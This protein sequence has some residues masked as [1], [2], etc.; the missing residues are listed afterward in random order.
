VNLL[1]GEGMSEKI[2]FELFENT[3]TMEVKK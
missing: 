1:G 2:K 3:K